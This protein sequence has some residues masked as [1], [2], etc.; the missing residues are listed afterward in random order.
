MNTKPTAA[1][2]MLASLLIAVPALAGNALNF[3]ARLSGAQ[4]VPPHESAA[5]GSLIVHVNQRLTE[6]TIK[7][8]VRNG[9]DILGAAGAHFHCAPAG[10]NGPVVVFLAG[11]FPPGYSGDFQV[12][13]SLSDSSIINPATACGGTIAELAMAMANGDV[14]VNVHSTA[15]PGGEIRGQVE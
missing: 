6:M 5:S 10:S 1:F 14:Y 7:L 11:T 15:N 8:D 9:T 13:A 4:E 2:A 3:K 12:R